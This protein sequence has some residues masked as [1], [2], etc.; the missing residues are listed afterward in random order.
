MT[1][2]VAAW[3]AIVGIVAAGMWGVTHVPGSYSAA[4]GADLDHAT[5]QM[6]R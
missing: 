4:V 6:A 2:R 3:A 1:R 5:A